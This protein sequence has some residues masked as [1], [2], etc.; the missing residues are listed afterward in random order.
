ML[1]KTT[2]SYQLQNEHYISA[3]FVFLT[4]HFQQLAIL[5]FFAQDIL[6]LKVY[7]RIVK[8]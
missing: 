2:M 1:L 5:L 6:S 4:G 8:K 3:L 7:N